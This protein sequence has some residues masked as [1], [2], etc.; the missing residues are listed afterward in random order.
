M[1]RGEENNGSTE[2]SRTLDNEGSTQGSRTRYDNGSK[3]VRRTWREQGS[4]D[5]NRT[6]QFWFDEIML[7]AVLVSNLE[8]GKFNIALCR[9][10]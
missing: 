10:H 3:E 1:G 6:E 7:K 4:T 8:K 9:F 2:G 5:R